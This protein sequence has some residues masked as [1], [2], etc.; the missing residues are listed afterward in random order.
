M[1][2][3]MPSASAQLV[4]KS[5]PSRPQMLSPKA[6]KNGGSPVKANNQSKEKRYL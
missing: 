4:N 2:F 5:I 1:D 3:F 6:P